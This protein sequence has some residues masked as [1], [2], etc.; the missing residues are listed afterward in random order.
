MFSHF[1]FL[2][3]SHCFPIL[4]VLS[5][6]NTE[7]V[8]CFQNLVNC[9][10]PTAYYW[11][12]IFGI[13]TLK[14]VETFSPLQFCRPPL[15]LLGLISWHIFS[16]ATWKCLQRCRDWTRIALKKIKEK[17]RQLLP[18]F[19]LTSITKER[20]FVTNSKVSLF[21]FQFLGSSVPTSWKE[22]KPYLDTIPD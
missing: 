11:L 8:Y 6:I 18:L 19:S 17:H 1:N 15:P 5:S 20:E 22:L 12:R 7:E 14:K 9:F 4:P 16:P 13:I 2:G 21:A 10:A 3:C